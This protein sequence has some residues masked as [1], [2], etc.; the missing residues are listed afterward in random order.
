[1]STL[2][3]LVRQILDIS[4]AKPNYTHAMMALIEV[5]VTSVHNSYAEQEFREAI[6]F[7]R[8]DMEQKF[9]APTLPQLD[10]VI[11]EF[12]ANRPK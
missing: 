11:A 10:H 6:T 4:G 3:D 7:L 8:H 5:Q 9:T 12:L 1:M 2:T